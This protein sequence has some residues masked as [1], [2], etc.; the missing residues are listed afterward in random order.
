MGNIRKFD[1]NRKSVGVD[2]A[3]A[4]LS[5]IFDADG[6]YCELEESDA[7]IWELYATNNGPTDVMAV[8]CKPFT[9][10]AWQ[11][12]DQL[13]VPAGANSKL[14]KT[15]RADNEDHF[16]FFQHWYGHPVPGGN[17]NC[18]LGIDGTGNWADM[19]WKTPP[20][21]CLALRIK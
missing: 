8:Y 10:G 11:I 19:W 9:F 16:F 21:L 4:T 2:R 6:F 5:N 1:L 13:S 3:L 18:Q 17:A 12:I 7:V 14:I 15:W 20:L